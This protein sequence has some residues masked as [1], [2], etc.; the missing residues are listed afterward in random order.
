MFKMVRAPKSN[1]VSLMG[2]RGAAF[3]GDGS[4]RCKRMTVHAVGIQGNTIEYATNYN[5]TECTGEAG[6]C[7]CIHAEEALIQKM[8]HPDMVIISHSPCINCAQMLVSAG[9]KKVYYI[10]EYR[11]RDGIEYLQEKRIEVRQL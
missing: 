7:G 11:I 3:F 6:N 10:H 9:V 1:A 5:I 4:M 8:P 2:L